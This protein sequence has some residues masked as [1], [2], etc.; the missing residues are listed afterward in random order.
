M[1]LPAKH[2]SPGEIQYIIRKL[3][4]KKAPG[5]DLIS[6]L[7]VKH[8]PEKSIIFLALICNCMFRLSY[9]P[10]AWKHSNINIIPKP[11]KLPDIPSS[12]R[13]ISLLPTF[14][15][16]FEKILLKRLLPLS[17]KF[18]IIP[19]HQFGFRSKHSNIH[20]LHRTVDLIS[21][22]MESKLYCAAV[23]LDVAQ[24]FD[25]VWHEGLLFKLKKFLPAPYYL[26]LKSYLG[27]RTFCVRVNNS[28]SSNFQ[29][30]A[31]VPQGNDIAPFLYSIFAH[32]TPTSPHTSLIT[33]Y[34]C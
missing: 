7:V 20:Q 27:N 5:H 10:T 2:T 19:N 30:L 16:I 21:I 29:I 24:A 25:K 12:Y 23:L 15:K 33:G 14:P 9:F 32:D 28:Y 17:D 31:G 34:I 4:T 3:P 11:D 1:A 26:L 18:N 13:P 6:N 8:L 22:S